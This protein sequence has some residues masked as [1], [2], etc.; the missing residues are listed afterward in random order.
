MKIGLFNDTFPPTIDGVAN[1]T[2]N[3]AVN[4]HNFGGD[5]TVITPHYP[6]VTDNYPFKVQRYPSIPLTKKIGYRAGAFMPHNIVKMMSRNFDI[7][8]THCPFASAVAVRTLRSGLIKPPSIFTYHTKFDIDIANRIGDEKLQRLTLKFILGNIKAMDEVWVVSNGAG[9]SL[10]QIGYDGAYRVM[11]NGV[12]FP[13]GEASEEIVQDIK[14]MYNLQEGAPNFLFVG[15]MMWYKNIKIILDALKKLQSD[16]INFRMI[17]V[18]DGKDRPAIEQ[19][20]TMQRLNDKVVFVG[21]VYDRERLRGFFTVA[22]LFLFPSTYDTSGL[23]VGE[24]AACN[25]ASLLVKNSAASD[26]IEDGVCG[27]LCEEN[28]ESAAKVI[29]AAIKSG[30]MREVG[31]TASRDIY[32]SWEEAVSVAHERYYKIL[33]KRKARKK[34]FF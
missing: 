27:Y 18:G 31:L 12:D 4:L 32:R 19:Y 15:R 6:H 1:A 28:A 3:Y 17:F 14:K 23:V 10:R 24:A 34:G 20:C 26:G 29:T 7:L 33:E 21:P 30:K 9:E 8:H 13:R 2:L 22:D 5:V 16:G 25:T 11:P